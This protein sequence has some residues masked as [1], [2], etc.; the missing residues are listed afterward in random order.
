MCVCVF[1]CVCVGGTMV[2]ML[3]EV[4]GLE[5]LNVLNIMIGYRF[6]K[7]EFFPS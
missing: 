2:V 4:D 5:K 1:V 3:E 7:N 6:T